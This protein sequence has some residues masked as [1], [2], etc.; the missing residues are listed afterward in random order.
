M[1]AEHTSRFIGPFL[2]WLQ[3]EISPATIAAVQ[4][5]VRKAAHLGEYAVLGALLLRAVTWGMEQVAWRW[6]GLAWLLALGWA[7]VD[8]FRQS[9]VPSR[10]G[11]PVDVAI[12]AT[13][14]LVGLLLFWFLF[15]RRG[16][17]RGG[18]AGREIVPWA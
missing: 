17:Q 14:A 18:G 9:F 1:S 2:R 3:P 16:R 15:L 10:T 7:A 11:S 5:L 6:A 4:L 8:E 13:G 12:D